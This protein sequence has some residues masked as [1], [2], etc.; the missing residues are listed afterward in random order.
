MGV[1]RKGQ[2]EPNNPVCNKLSPSDVPLGL[3][4]QITQYSVNTNLTTTPNS[5]VNWDNGNPPTERH[6]WDSRGFFL[7]HNLSNNV[8]LNLLGHQPKALQCTRYSR[9][10]GCR[11]TLP[12]V[13]GP[14]T[15]PAPSPVPGPREAASQEQSSQAGRFPP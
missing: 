6:R 13:T 2:R 14:S 4:T 9:G 10:R 11:D 5:Q 8:F 15:G 7:Y 1:R 12:G 3:V